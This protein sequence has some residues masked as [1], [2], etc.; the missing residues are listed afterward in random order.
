MRLCVWEIFESSLSWKE[1]KPHLLRRSWERWL[2]NFRIFR[3]LITESRSHFESS[4]M[5]KRF[6]EVSLCRR[7]A[8]P[9]RAQSLRIIETNSLKSCRPQDTHLAKT[10]LLGQWL[11]YSVWTYCLFAF[12][13][14]TR[15]FRPELFAS[16]V[17]CILI[18]NIT[19][20]YV[21]LFQ[22]DCVSF[23][24]RKLYSCLETFLCFFKS[25]WSCTD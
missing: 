17:C 12:Y 8:Q 24:L 3:A 11:I 13:V 18:T 16:T 25:I 14:V 22:S 7:C 21:Q 10:L 5:V 23:T 4:E 15:L 6:T 1:S 20:I 19:F 9:C 2:N